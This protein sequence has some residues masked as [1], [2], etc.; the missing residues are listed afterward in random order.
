[1]D[2][3]EHLSALREQLVKLIIHQETVFSNWVKFIITIQVGLAA[4]LGFV[5]GD[6]PH[7][8]ELG[9]VIAVSGIATAVLFAK[10]LV[11]H[12][13]WSVWY[14]NRCKSLTAASQ[15]FPIKEGEI[16]RQP[17]GPVVRWTRYFL[18]VVATAW[19]VLMILMFF[20]IVL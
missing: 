9:Y 10:I 20:K 8:R 7:R 14:I 11:R 1:M 18:L 15:I 19:I 12:N 17:L 5:L 4:G 16:E 13:Q 3:T 6:L 2:D